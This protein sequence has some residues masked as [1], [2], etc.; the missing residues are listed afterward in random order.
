LSR[1]E[2]GAD[3]SIGSFEESPA[4]ADLVIG[5]PKTTTGFSETSADEAV[6]A[7]IGSS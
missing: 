5:L 3:S 1:E 2:A 6:G 7:M 4:E